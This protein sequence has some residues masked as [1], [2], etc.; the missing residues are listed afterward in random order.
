MK[1]ILT[2]G[3]F[4]Y[5]HLLK[6]SSPE[7]HFTRIRYFSFL[8]FKP[9][10]SFTVKIMTPVFLNSCYYGNLSQAYLFE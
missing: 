2:V 6:K 7:H 10:L 4:L 9:K 1:D 3:Y 5:K 8:N